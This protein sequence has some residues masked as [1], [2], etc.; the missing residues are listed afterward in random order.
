MALSDDSSPPLRKDLR[1]SP[2]YYRGELCYVVKDP[3]TLDYYRLGEVEYAV[4]ECFQ[5]GMSVEA[6]RQEV[7][8]KTGAELTAIEVYKFVHQLRASNLLKSKGMG[9]VPRLV[10]NRDKQRKNKIKQLLSN[11]L[12]ITIPVWDPDRV[13]EKLLPYFRFFLRPFFLVCCLALG[14]GALWVVATNFSTLVADAFSVLSGWNI[15]IL[16]GVVFSMKL[17]HEMA[18]ALTCKHFGGEVHAIGPAFLVFQPCMFTDTSD[19]WLLPDKWQRIAVTGAGISA[20]LLLASVSALVWISSEPGFIKQVSYTMMVASSISSI[21]FNANPLLRFDGYYILADLLEIPNMRAKTN[22][23]LGYLFERYLL[24]IKDAERPQMKDEDRH[25]YLLYGVSRFIY[26]IFIVVMIGFFLYS[27]FEP[28]GVAMWI[29]SIYG[30]VVGPMWK[31]GKKI[32]RRYK[33]GGVQVRYLLLLV[34]AVAVVGGLW[35]I[36]IDYTVQAPCVVAPRAMSVVRT[37]E[38]G[39]IEKVM[40]S[41]G[42]RV[43]KGEVLAR[44]KNPELRYRAENIRQGIKE[45]D[46]RIRAALASDTADYLMKVRQREKLKQELEKIEE[47]LERLT[48]RAPHSGVVVNVHRAEMKTSQ[49]QNSFVSFPP[50]SAEHDLSDL[51]GMTVKAGMGLLAVAQTDAFVFK[52]FV[53]EHKVSSLSRGNSLK[54][55]LRTKVSQTYDG[56]IESIAPVDVKKI[57]NV[58]ITL[59]DVGYI[60]VENTQGGEKKPLVTLYVVRSD[61]KQDVPRSAIGLTGKAR[62]TYDSGPMGNYYFTKIVTALKLRLQK[63]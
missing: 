15:L 17:F 62:I 5:R 51:E 60:P 37:A 61:P 63:A 59:A 52:T 40:V 53:P 25:V 1:V 30:M 24:G 19:A 27:L 58:G 9:D 16:S 35:F 36:P 32:A 26:R 55:M 33:S 49:S 23:Y 21:M 18:H 28:L 22:N 56:K 31:R 14:A 50:G 20:E 12:F 34:L 46:A 7:Y 13:L 10:E 2:Q 42:E 41:P 3:V 11:Y 54:C 44:M 45:T 39:R 6:A 29:T 48:V 57:E 4:L 47:R 8:D 38:P 43:E